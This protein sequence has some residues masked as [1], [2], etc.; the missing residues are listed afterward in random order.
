MEKLPETSRGTNS[1]SQATKGRKS[2]SGKKPR[3]KECVK[4]WKRDIMVHAW[5]HQA[6]WYETHTLYME[7]RW[8]GGRL[9]PEILKKETV[10]DQIR[11]PL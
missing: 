3:G 2:I 4:V 6:V 1:V 7:D 9:L 10:K 11:S 5:K 8:D